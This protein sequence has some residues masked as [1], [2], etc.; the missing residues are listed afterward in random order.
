[1]QWALVSRRDENDRL[2]SSWEQ[3]PVEERP[4]ASD[5]F[6]KQFREARIGLR[7]TL[8]A[9]ADRVGTTAV[10]VSGVERGVNG[11]TDEEKQEWWWALDDLR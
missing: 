1:M 8:A 11:L 6:G 9:V 10:V 3:I 7:I 4:F 2:Y 5:P